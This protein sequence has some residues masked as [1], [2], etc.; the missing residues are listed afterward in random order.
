MRTRGKTMSE[1][2]PDAP[3]PEGVTRWRKRP[4]VVDAIRWT[5]DNLAEVLEFAG[6]PYF[7][8]VPPE[9]RT[10]DPDMTAEVFD[11][12]HS[13]WVHVYDGQWIIRGVQGELYPIAADVLVATY[14][15]VDG[16]VAVA[17][18]SVPDDTPEVFAAAPERTEP[19]PAPSSP[20]EAIA[21]AALDRAIQRMRTAEGE[22]FA[23]R[24]EL[25][26]AQNAIGQVLRKAGSWQMQGGV[27]TTW[28]VA[29][30][31]TDTLAP[32]TGEVRSEE[33]SRG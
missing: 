15:P 1:P 2:K 24:T 4:V 7:G 18:G 22:V 33:E 27:I 26:S 25:A 32:W 3:V 8:A 11:K 17:A 21:Y 13:T 12:L 30:W 19:R 6:G 9:D 31:L 23:V 10:E 28:A 5:G 14:E 29:R 16:T 20:G